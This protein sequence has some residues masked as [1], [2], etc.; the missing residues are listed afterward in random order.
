M[1]EGQEGVTWP[2]WR[3][4]AAACEE[5]G[6]PSLF[7]SDHYQNLDGRHPERGSLDAWGTIIALSALTTELRLGTMVTPT[8]FR[9]PSVLA[10]LVVT[11]D[12]VSDGRIDLGL[13]AGWHQR[14]HEAH[15][16]PFLAAAERVDVL[17]EQIQILMGDWGEDEFSFTGKHY[18][19]S[20]LNA[21]PKPVQRPH[22]PLIMGGNAGPRSASLAA[23]FA[24]E[25]NTPFPSLEHIQRRKA[26]VEE[27]CERAGREPIPFSIMAGAILGADAGEVERRARRV[28]EATGQEPDALLRDPPQGWI[29]G[30]L[31]QTA[32]QLAPIREAGVSRVMC[33]Q[34]VAP[35][36]EQ[37]ARL[38]EL[39]SM[40][41]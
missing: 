21:Q 3:A 32:E 29:V 1:I 19:L 16:F 15:G 2:Q 6:I 25:Y 22:P 23:R 5:H 17:E 11:A 27:A 31:E 8:S 34:Y 4:L 28:A 40:L 14:E 41:A 30:T 10:K 38:G 39:A 12:H 9:H 37:V 20:G 24:D 13:G 26:A 36:V 18:T 35:E 7:R 33:N